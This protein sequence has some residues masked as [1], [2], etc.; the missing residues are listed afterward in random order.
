[1]S[2][3]KKTTAAL[4]V[5]IA[6]DIY[7]FGRTT[8]T[9][10]ASGE[11]VHDGDTW[12]APKNAPELQRP[13]AEI[14]ADIAA[15]FEAKYDR[16]PPASALGDAMMVI[17]GKARQT[18]PTEPTERLLAMLAG[19]ASKAT[20]L[21]Q[22]AREHYRFGVTTSGDVFAVPVAGPNIARPLRGG[23]RSLRGELARLFYEKTK[24]AANAQALADALVVL[25]GDAAGTDPAEVALRVGRD[26]ATGDLVLDLGRDDGLVVVIGAHGWEVTTA[27]P[28][29]FWRTNATL[30]LPVPA[31][32]GSL[33]ELRDLLNLPGEDWPLVVAW[34]VAALMP[35]IPHP[36]L[37][38]RGEHG[39]AK[40]TSARLLTSLVD[41]CASQLRTAPRNV[42][43][44][45]VTAAGSWVTCLDNVSTLPG[46]LQDAIC[47]AVTGD[48][49][50]RRELYTNA[51]VAVLAFRRVIAITGIDPGPLNG[52]LADR[53]LAMEPE[54]IAE[55]ARSAEEDVDVTWRRVHPGVLG[56]LLDVACDVLRILPSVRRADLPRMAD[57]ARVVLAV[58][59]VLGTA[60]YARYAE[61]AGRTAEIVAD[62]D[63]VIVAIR[64]R[65]T[66]PWEGPAGDLLDKLTGDRPPADWPSTPQGMGGRLKRAAPVLR[67]LGWAV[68]HGRDK[69]RRT[70]I[71]SPPKVP[72]AEFHPAQTSSTS[73]MSSGTSDLGKHDD[74]P[75]DV[76]PADDDLNVIA[77]PGCHREP[78]GHDVDD[79]DDMFAGQS[80]V[81]GAFG[82]IPA[83]PDAGP[84]TLCGRPCM[85]YG[86][87]GNPLCETCQANTEG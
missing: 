38:L 75:D 3:G 58:D 51:D 87:R 73:S 30:P 4:L 55:D 43:D 27:S 8:S 62:S 60:G 57:F 41:R 28:V 59:K 12:A 40:S 34:L 72:R 35:G 20:Q 37:L 68:D 67:S 31:G 19:A 46:W 23:R 29:L 71:V 22:M 69:H 6:E 32:G 10:S 81:P 2:E 13:L 11:L 48:G 84:C 49:M 47:R 53:L 61:Q 16:P 36:V 14:R 74:N 50:L 26:P 9:H 33:D 1:V 21:V 25:E 64:R 85:R 66:E 86:E 7:V 44:W 77:G 56:A 17:E 39:T 15:V 52:D 83:G 79:V 24:G 42:E 76:S 70:W 65:I 54:R 5:E 45:A 78:A 63:P 82:T 80:S 18:E